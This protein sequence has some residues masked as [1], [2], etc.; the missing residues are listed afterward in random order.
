VRAATRARP[1]APLYIQPPTVI[2]LNYK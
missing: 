2:N 1:M